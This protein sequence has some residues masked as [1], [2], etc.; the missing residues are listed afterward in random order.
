MVLFSSS[1]TM[2]AG[3]GSEPRLRIN[4]PMGEA[5]LWSNWNADPD[6]APIFRH[7]P[8]RFLV[9]DLWQLLCSLER[10]PDETAAENTPGSRAELDQN[11]TA[12]IWTSANK[13]P[14]QWSAN[15]FRIPVSVELIWGPSGHTC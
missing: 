4:I 3:D 7:T 15:L 13:H 1:K 11:F 6:L 5:L 8:T 14:S 10:A 2:K 12:E 9:P